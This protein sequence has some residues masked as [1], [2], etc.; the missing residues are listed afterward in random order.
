MIDAHQHFWRLDRGDYYWMPQDPDSA[1]R[2]D[3]GPADLHPI[4][5]KYG[6]TGTVLVQAAPTEGETWFMLDIAKNEPL[7]KGVVGWTEF[8]AEDAPERIAA[9]GREGKLVGF[10]P[11]IQDLP[12]DGWMLRDD[13][14]PAFQAIIDNDLAFDALTFPRH[15]PNLL[16]FIARWP[17]MRIVV[18]HCSKPQIRDDEFQPWADLI[19]AVAGHPGICCKLS[20]IVTEA[21]PDWTVEKLRPYAEHVVSAFGPDRVMWGSDWPVV[22]L[23]GG[24]ERWRDAAETIFSGLSGAEKDAIF[25]GTATRFYRL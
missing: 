2:Q 4:A 6:I 15:L 3:Y 19:T 25:G 17:D 23:A 24:Y 14:A 7:V 20:G 9:L 1:L 16:T 13:L 18:D 22:N 10:R 5:E 21:R 11:M 12:D 8:E